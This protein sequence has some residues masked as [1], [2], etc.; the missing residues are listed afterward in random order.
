LR[1]S[2]SAMLASVFTLLKCLP[3]VGV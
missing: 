1:R 2:C 3:S